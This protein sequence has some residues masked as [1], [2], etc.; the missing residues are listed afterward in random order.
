MTTGF[1]VTAGWDLPAG[2]QSQAHA[3][4]AMA[5]AAA[6]HARLVPAERA[7]GAAPEAGP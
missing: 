3:A 5:G 2:D 7:T 6:G 1:A 4:V